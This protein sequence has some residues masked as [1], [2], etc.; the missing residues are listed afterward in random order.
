MK[1]EEGLCA[2]GVI[3]NEHGISSNTIS[4]TR[5]YQDE[6]IKVVVHMTSLVTGNHEGGGDDD[7][8]DSSKGGNSS[9]PLVVS[10]VKGNGQ[11]LEF[12]VT[13]YALQLRACRLRTRMLLKTIFLM[14]DLTSGLWMRTCRGHS[15][16]T[17]RSGE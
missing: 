8:E 1:V 15:T 3:F 7:E 11:F 12:G 17:W 9:I 16:S 10:V 4:L 14:R 5:K 6:V 13:A 2:G